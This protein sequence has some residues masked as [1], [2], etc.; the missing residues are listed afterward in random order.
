MVIEAVKQNGNALQ[1]ATAELKVDEE[2]EDPPHSPFS[3]LF[4]FGQTWTPC[5]LFLILNAKVFLEAVK[6]QGWQVLRFVSFQFMRQQEMDF[7]DSV[8]AHHGFAFFLH[9][10]RPRKACADSVFPWLRLQVKALP[11]EIPLIMLNHLGYYH[12]IILK[13]LIAG[14]AGVAL[15]HVSALRRDAAKFIIRR[16]RSKHRNLVR[17]Q[18]LDAEIQERVGLFFGGNRLPH[19]KSL[20]SPESI[21]AR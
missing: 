15:G 7:W 3:T 6:Q 16:D 5:L 11:Q 17:L 14:Y 20:G 19:S 13:R 10:I 8:D 2:V 12:G 18:D 1:F 9:G 21:G 4:L